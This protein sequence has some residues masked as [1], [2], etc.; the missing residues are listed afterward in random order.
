[1]KVDDYT[2]TSELEE[3][4]RCTTESTANTLTVER[5]GYTYGDYEDYKT[6][7]IFHSGII[8][9]HVIGKAHTKLSNWTFRVKNKLK[10]FRRG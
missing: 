7:D 2:C 6:V 4:L 5:V 8:G 10:T 1:M 9:T 3:F